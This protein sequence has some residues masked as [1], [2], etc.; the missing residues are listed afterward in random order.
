MLRTQDGGEGAGRRRSERG[1]ERVV[2]CERADTA[3][4][5]KR[6][7]RPPLDFVHP[8]PNLVTSLSCRASGL[9][10]PPCPSPPPWISPSSRISSQAPRS[11][12][13]HFYYAR[14][15]PTLLPPDATSRDMHRTS[16]PHTYSPSDRRARTRS[17][18][19]HPNCPSF[20]PCH[21]TTLSTRVSSPLCRRLTTHSPRSCRRGGLLGLSVRSGSNTSC[22]LSAPGRCG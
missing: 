17:H 3:E 15:P 9:S 5:S 11:P 4:R 1:R 10:C 22:Y 6:V 21:G 7:Q 20:L 16:T 18:L 12:H 14:D 8:L 13:C 19:P 2:G